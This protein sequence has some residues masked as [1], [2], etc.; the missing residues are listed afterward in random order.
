MSAD[1]SAENAE[2]WLQWHMPITH[3]TSNAEQCCGE[4]IHIY[5]YVAF[6]P[7]GL[8]SDLLYGF[9]LAT[10]ECLVCLI[11]SCGRTGN[12]WL[13]AMHMPL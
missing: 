9:G 13:D 2:C 10:V 3:P 6:S 11:S 12:A 4:I 5:H 1:K 8:L 7:N